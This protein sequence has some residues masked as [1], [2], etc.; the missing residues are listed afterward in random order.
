MRHQDTPITASALG[1]V[2]A[3]PAVMAS[4]FGL[5]PDRGCPR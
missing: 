4:D 1:R 2:S 3:A 5:A